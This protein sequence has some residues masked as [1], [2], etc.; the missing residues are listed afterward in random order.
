MNIKIILIGMSCNVDMNVYMTMN[1]IYMNVYM[2]MN[3]ID[4]N[5]EI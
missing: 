1:T 4:M 2:T 5:V 3:N